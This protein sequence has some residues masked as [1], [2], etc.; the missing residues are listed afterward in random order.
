MNAAAKNKSVPTSTPDSTSK[1]DATNTSN[2]PDTTTITPRKIRILKI[3]QCPNLSESAQLTYHVGVTDEG[4]ILFRVHANSGSG[5][6]S[7]EWVSLNAIK[8]ASDKVPADKPIT[9]IILTPLYVG[10]STNNASFLFAVLKQ[11]GFV[12]QSVADPRCYDRIN[13]TNFMAEIEALISSDVSLD[14]DAKPKPKAKKKV[15]SDVA[16]STQALPTAV[17]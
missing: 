4:E 11:E 12:Q 2:S 16:A 1:P 15:A 17:E 13:P 9:S 6:F 10:R 5:Y 7:R 3:A 8:Q 14:A